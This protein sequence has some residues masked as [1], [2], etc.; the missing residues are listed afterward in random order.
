MKL[1]VIMLKGSDEPVGIFK[2]SLYAKQTVA[3]LKDKY[4]D[5]KEFKIIVYPLKSMFECDIPSLLA[6]V[7]IY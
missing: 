5:D 4:G 6:P 2:N 1:Y 7:Y 3:N